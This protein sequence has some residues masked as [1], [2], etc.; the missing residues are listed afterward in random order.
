L[1]R[2]LTL[3][4]LLVCVP[5][6]PVSAWAGQAQAPPLG[7]F[8]GYLWFG[9]VSSVHAS[10]T[11]PRVQRGSPPGIG[12]TWIGAQ[13]AA[14]RAFIQIGTS[15]D[16]FWPK[17]NRRAAG[18]DFA[19]WSDI[20]HHFRAQRIFAV[21]PGNR[22]SAT[23]KLAS[24]RWTLAITDL[25]SGAK[26]QISTPE[27]ANA[28]FNAAEWLQEDPRS[29]ATHAPVAYP[30]LSDVRFADLEVNRR[31]ARYAALYSLWM[32]LRRITLAP[33]SLRK[34]SFYIHQAKPI[35]QT[36][37]R[38]LRI[39]GGE[40]VAVEAF[41]AQISAWSQATPIAQVSAQRTM[42]LAALQ[43]NIHALA[44]ASWPRPIAGLI[45]KLLHA[46]RTLKSQT[47]IQPQLE[48]S[49]L[50]S[51]RAQWIK[52]LAAVGRVAHRLRRAL[53]IP[54]ITPLSK[55]SR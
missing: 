53:R 36:G 33:S 51:W 30:K 7:S 4:F 5:F 26:F 37:L 24:G 13:A 29:A 20:G 41:G 50:H 43:R 49:S 19:F 15:E 47:E 52:D 46:T 34:D 17:H 38:Y 8:A 22:I 31:R 35:S 44:S 11:V 25:T 9:H 18:Y 1:L 27:E 21:Q 48:A 55:P 32:S 39:V 14:D 23:I 40:A 6:T 45:A 2:G 12:G 28:S 54:D 42:F 3:A 10:W 16:G